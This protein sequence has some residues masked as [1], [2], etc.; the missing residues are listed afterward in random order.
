MAAFCSPAPCINSRR[1]ADFLLLSRFVSSRF[2]RRLSVF[3]K[4]STG[5][6]LSLPVQLL[7][8]LREGA[9][10]PLTST[11]KSTARFGTI[12]HCVNLVKIGVSAPTAESYTPRMQIVSSPYWL[13]SARG[14]YSV[15]TCKSS[16]RTNGPPCALSP[17]TGVSGIMDGGKFNAQ[18]V[19]GLGISETT[20]FTVD[21]HRRA[22]NK[23]ELTDV[24][25]RRPC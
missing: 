5:G 1:I 18:T 9:G 22:A 20:Q 25:A 3:V 13:N 15:R 24:P 8:E 4:S 14:S 21:R 11:A 10:A 12:F 17:V 2:S 7:T 6:S 16:R 19:R 23:L